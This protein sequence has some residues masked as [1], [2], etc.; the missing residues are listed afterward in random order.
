MRFVVYSLCNVRCLLN[1]FSCN[2]V[3]P[4]HKLYIFCHCQKHRRSTVTVGLIHNTMKAL[5]VFVSL[6]IWPP[7]KWNPIYSQN[8]LWYSITSQKNTVCLVVSICPFSNPHKRVTH[9]LFCSWSLRNTNCAPPP[10]KNTHSLLHSVPYTH[11]TL[12][13]TLTQ[14][15]VFYSQYKAWRQVL[16]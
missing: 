8:V 1:A 5:L 2:I 9:V 12:A 14:H 11:C 15:T 4:G 3:C 6:L 10:L 16:D 13:F 7:A